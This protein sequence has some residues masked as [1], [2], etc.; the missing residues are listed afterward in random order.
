MN[1]TNNNKDSSLLAAV[2]LGSNSFHMVVAK[3]EHGEVRP[4]ESF[5]D[6]VQLA[7]GMKDGMLS[8]E[9]V[10]RGLD[11]LRR[12]RQ[13]L[14]SYKPG[15]V[16]IVGTNALR[17]AK[18]GSQFRRAAADIMG[19]MVEVIPG[20]EEARLVYLGV[21]H[22]LADDDYARLVVDIGGGST[23]F[24]IGERFEA[25]LMESLHMGCVS[26]SDRYFAGG[27][28]NRKNFESAY[29]AASSEVSYIC[30]EYCERGWSNAVG[31]SGTLRAIEGV[32]VAHGWATAGISAENLHKLRDVVLKHKTFESLADLPGL[33]EKRRDVFAAGVAITCAFFDALEIDVMHTSTGA[34]R[35][36]VIY[37]LIGRQSHEDVRERTVNALMQRYGIDETRA[38]HVED[39]ALQLF[40]MVRQ[41]WT[42]TPGDRDL[43]SWASRL[44]EI[45]MA[46][47]HTQFHKHG[48]YL[49]TNSDLQGFSRIE[50]AELALLV[51]SHRRKFPVAEL[52]AGVG[53]MRPSLERLSLLLRLAVL[54]KFVVP[55]E[56]TTCFV[57]EVDNKKRLK[58]L[59]PR[60]WL[61]HHPLTRVALEQEEALLAKAGYTLTTGYQP[62]SESS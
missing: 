49:V 56:E 17:A 5:A 34:V 29:L 46:V 55:M 26:Y 32:I 47:S 43:L 59:F 27:V 1:E 16:R 62:R 23:E 9:A 20:R 11:C 45:G 50:Q 25:R 41:T 18:N 53:T 2:D 60:G 3:V 8:E 24:I 22:T 52:A 54:F 28:I 58:L 7:A 42:L 12:F 10:A 48:Q 15:A 38:R 51:R 30:R 19:Q 33:G 35:E 36:G 4:L 57:L 61:Q 31:S 39:M 14:D 44:H 40:D 21:A 6:R 13:A 37:D